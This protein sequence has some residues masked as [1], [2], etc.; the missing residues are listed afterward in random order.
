MRTFFNHLAKCGGTSIN[1]HA[2]EE[3]KEDF[4]LLTSQTTEAELIQWLAKDKCFI[5]SELIDINYEQIG[6]ILKDESLKKIIVARDPVERFKSF[7][8]H[9]SRDASV[10]HVRYWGNEKNIMQR[11]DANNWL[12]SS[13]KR[14]EYILS[15]KDE[16]SLESLETQWVFPIYSQ[17]FL[18][19]YKCCYNFNESLLIPPKPAN[20]RY[21]IEKTRSLTN[22]CNN[23]NIDEGIYKFTRHFYDAWGTTD[24][25]DKFIHKLV[26]MG[27]FTSMPKE[28]YIDNKS[29][30]FQ[31]LNP[32]LFDIKQSLIAHYYALIPEDFLFHST[33]RVDL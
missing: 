11:I 25:L 21:H 13:L 27:I 3:Y 4:H 32:V 5:S 12:R 20:V 1:K 2:K 19:S 31:N 26:N 7:C 8:G 18:A 15:Q 6:I 29:K 24:Q 9:S 22:N 28:M 30:E 33:C 17:W 10:D 16:L 14:M 23:M